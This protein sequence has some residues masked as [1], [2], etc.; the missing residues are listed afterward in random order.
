MTCFSGGTLEIYL[1]PQLPLPRLLVVGN[2][3][4]ARALVAL[5]KV[6]DYDVVVVD[7]DHHLAGGA[8][9]VVTDLADIARHIR[10]DTYVVVA[11]HGTNDEAAL[12]AV[13][14]ARPRYV[15]LVASHKR[16]E[17]VAEYLRAQGI[18]EAALQRI[19]APAGLDIGAQQGDEIALS[20]MAEIVQLRRTAPVVVEDAAGPV[21]PALRPGIA[22][23]PVCQMEVEIAS[24]KYSY[25]YG[26]QMYYFCAPGCKRE[27]S[28]NPQEYLTAQ[29][30]P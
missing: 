28:K 27:F 16:F 26:G 20:I 13:L 29:V 30:K 12:E 11:T 18:E 19:K 2:L 15:G 17:S 4:V 1:E 5:G 3:P 22:I 8:D 6:M 14:K 21:A 23:D 24:A 7:P 25:E 10:P 9:H